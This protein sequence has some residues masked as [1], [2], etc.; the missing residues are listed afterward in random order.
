MK[1]KIV[2]VKD[3]LYE[4]IRDGNMIMFTRTYKQCVIFVKKIPYD[5]KII[6]KENK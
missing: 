4:V 6:Q 3:G 5:N 1:G 2:E